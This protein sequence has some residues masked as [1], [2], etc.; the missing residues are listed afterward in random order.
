MN[1]RGD[2]SQEME[3][4]DHKK[5]NDNTDDSTDDD[6]LNDSAPDSTL[7]PNHA[8]VESSTT[9]SQ[10]SFAILQGQGY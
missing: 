7:D 3:S 10:L 2:N 5:D 9:G 4:H 6:D 8:S 1:K